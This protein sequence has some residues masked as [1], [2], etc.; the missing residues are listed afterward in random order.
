MEIKK[1]LLLVYAGAGKGKT[2]AALGQTLRALGQGL[3][4]SFIQF[5]KRDVQ[6][7]EQKMLRELL[8]KA[9]YPGGA[10]FFRAEAERERHRAAALESLKLAALEARVRD[11]LVLDEVLYAL[12]TGLILE[13]ELRELIR[14]CRGAGTHLVLSGRFLPQW[15]LEEADLVTE[16]LPRKHYY[17]TGAKARRGLEF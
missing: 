11:M 16:M 10:G 3:K 8:G 9:F 17:E 6:A 14:L 15:L 2:S 12:E 5:I 7:G 13:E 4:L 1:S